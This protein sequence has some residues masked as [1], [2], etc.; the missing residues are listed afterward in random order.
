LKHKGKIGMI[1]GTDMHSPNG[2]ASGGVHG[3]TSLNLNEITEDAL[4][5]ELRKKN[6]YIL[7]SKK[8]YLDPKYLN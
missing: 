8:P 3:W 5:E 1:T 7:Y 6:T 4:M 2:L